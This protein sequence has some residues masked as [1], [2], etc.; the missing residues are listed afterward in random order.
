MD[1]YTILRKAVKDGIDRDEALFLLKKIRDWETLQEL[2]KVA[3][4]VR[5]DEIGTEIKL[6]G[7]LCS[8]TPCT[9]N[10]PCKYCFRWANPK[11]FSWD[12]VLSNDELEI[13]MKAIQEIGLKRAELGGGTYTGIIGRDYTLYKLRVAKQA[14][15]YVGIWVT[16]VSFNPEDLHLLMGLVEGITSNLES[17]DQSTYRVLRPGSDLNKRINILLD[18][19][20]LGIPTD[21]TL[22]IGLSI[23]NDYELVYEEWIRFLMLVRLLKHFKILEIH[24]FRPVWGS[25]VQDMKPGSIIETIKMKAIA[26]IML[27][28]IWISGAER[29]D[30]L[31]AGANL[32]MHVYPITKSFRPWGYNKIFSSNVVRLADNIVL[33][34]NLY[35]VTRVPRELG[36]SIE[37]GL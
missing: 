9:T 33:V 27:R 26:R 7:F 17:I 2:M 25:P 22:M 34:D 6:M 24:P 37:G 20:K 11:L 36:F 35:E 31:M 1:V 32:I 8:I 19:D 14:A 16:N 4:K 13:G 23:Y 12:D 18:A 3:S 28:D 30:G 10:P 15:P 21:T 5:D 29:I